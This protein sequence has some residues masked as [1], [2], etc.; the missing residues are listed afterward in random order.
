MRS[1]RAFCCLMRFSRACFANTLIWL[2]A[3]PVFFFGCGRSCCCNGG[4][5]VSPAGGVFGGNC[6]K[7]EEDG[8]IGRNDCPPCSLIAFVAGVPCCFEPAVVDPALEVGC[9]NACC[10]VWFA[11]MRISCFSVPFDFA[12]DGI[13]RDV[14]GSLAICALSTGT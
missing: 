5:C 2:T 14:G 10:E 8:A 11:P 13:G 7:F 1:L 4:R 12:A 9:L 3:G 6:F